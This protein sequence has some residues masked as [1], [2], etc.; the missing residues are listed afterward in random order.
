[1][2][3]SVKKI[4]YNE[5][6]WIDLSAPLVRVPS[7]VLLCFPGAG[8]LGCEYC[9]VTHAQPI[10]RRKITF[11]FSTGGGGHRVRVRVSERERGEERDM[12][13]RWKKRDR[14]AVI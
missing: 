7:S 3:V 8:W 9:T 4:K 1:M 14:D 2:S 13:E 6:K 12:R 5:K 11:T 10:D